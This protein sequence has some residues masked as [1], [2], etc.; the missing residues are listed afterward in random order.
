MRLLSIPFFPSPPK[1]KLYSRLHVT[2]ESTQ[3]PFTH[4]FLVLSEVSY[5]GKHSTSA[6]VELR[7]LIL[8]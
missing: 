6:A 2:F 7:D 3:L 1:T 4:D 8:P 5:P